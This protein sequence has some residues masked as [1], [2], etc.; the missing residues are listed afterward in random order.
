MATRRSAVAT[1]RSATASGLRSRS[2]RATGLR[3]RRPRRPVCLRE[4]KGSPPQCRRCCAQRPTRSGYAT[5]AH[6]PALRS[7]RRGHPQSRHPPQA[8]A[9]QQPESRP[10]RPPAPG[11]A[12]AD[13]NSRSVRAMPIRR[14]SLREVPPA[15]QSPRAI[16]GPAKRVPGAATRTRAAMA[17]SAPGPRTTPC[18]A[19]ITGTLA[20]STAWQSWA[21]VGAA[22]SCTNRQPT[23]ECRATYGNHDTPDTTGC[24]PM[25]RSAPREV[26]EEDFSLRIADGQDP[27]IFVVRDPQT[28][29][30]RPHA[31]LQRQPRRN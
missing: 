19:A 16:S 12:R 15:G 3:A 5:F 18:K 30:R 10:L 20:D 29:C 31:L 27:D 17:S 14:P 6:Q 26:T 13:S 11:Q 7:R 8:L 28:P 1:D 2:W 21:R 24:P 4:K 23:G 25:S 22:P 9:R